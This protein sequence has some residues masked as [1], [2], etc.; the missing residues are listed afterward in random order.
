MDITQTFGAALEESRSAILA[1]MADIGV[2]DERTGR[3]SHDPTPA[4]VNRGWCGEFAAAVVSRFPQAEARWLDE[5]GVGGD[6]AG[7]MVVVF[8]GRYYDAECLDGVEP[9]DVMT[10]P[11]LREARAGR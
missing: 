1:E 4:D 8:G 5:L 10:L 2:Y 7:H 3:L 6:A 11:C 9:R